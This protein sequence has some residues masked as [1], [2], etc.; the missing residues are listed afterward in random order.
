LP[1]DYIADTDLRLSI[2]Q[3][4]TALVSVEQTEDLAKELADRFGPLPIEVK[5][6][7]YVLKLRLLATR[8]GVES[9]ASN[10][11]LGHHPFV[12]GKA[13]RSAEADPGAEIRCLKSASSSL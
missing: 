1:E 5:N 12:A 2:Y 13:V 6:L 11:N 8:A 9:V 3:R 4:F 10:D 7:I